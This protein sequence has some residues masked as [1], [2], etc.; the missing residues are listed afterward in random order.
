MEILIGREQQ[1]RRL[2]V[3]RDGV[4]KLVGPA[5][6][7]PMDVSRQHVKFSSHGDDQWEIVNLNSMNVTYVNGMAIEKKIISDTD[8]VELGASRFL[9]NWDIVRG[10][11]VEIIDISH[12]EA[13]WEEYHKVT[14]DMKRRNRRLGLAQS[15]PMILSLS[16]GLLGRLWN[17]N[18]ILYVIGGI[19]LVVYLVTF[20]LRANDKS[21]DQEEDLKNWLHKN[22]V[23][24]KCGCYMG[25][26]SFDLLIQTNACPH[27]KAKFKK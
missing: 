23:C 11:K 8:K 25:D 9:L 27:C 19:S 6:C 1:S 21:I 17:D 12:L 18:P 22:Y 15:F 26:R 10:P 14:L 13:V 24:P 5:G 20:L 7:V 4:T 2:S 16:S 3:T